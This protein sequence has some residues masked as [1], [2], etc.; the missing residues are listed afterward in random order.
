MPANCFQYNYMY[1]RFLEYM[2]Q[3]TGH[4][5]VMHCFQEVTSESQVNWH[6]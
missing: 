2:L 5:A 1:H 6:D 3:V 4:E